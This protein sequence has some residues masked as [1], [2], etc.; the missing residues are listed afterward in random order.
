[1]HGVSV[2]RTHLSSNLTSQRTLASRG[3][4]GNGLA[5]IEEMVVDNGL[6]H[7]VLKG[8]EEALATQRLGLARRGGGC[9]RSDA[10]ETSLTMQ[11]APSWAA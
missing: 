11:N 2:C 7:L 8:G 4:N 10:D 9:Q 3:S 6:V 1:M 5:R